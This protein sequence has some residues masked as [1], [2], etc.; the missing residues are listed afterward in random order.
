MCSRRRG[1][2]APRLRLLNL[3][4]LRHPFQRAAFYFIGRIFG[5]SPKHRLFVAMYSGIGLAL[6]I[7]SLFVL[8]G[9]PDFVLSISRKGLIE[10]PLIL[11]FFVVSGLRATFNLPYELGANWMFQITSGSDAAEYLKATRKWVFLQGHSSG[12]CGCLRR[13]ISCFSTGNEASF[14]WHSVWPLPQC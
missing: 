11:S 12:L 14:I 2:N 9:I 10:A 6:V 8:R 5:R 1:I 7:S 13:S 3:T 4:L